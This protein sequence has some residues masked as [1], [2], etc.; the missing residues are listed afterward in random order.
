MLAKSSST[1]ADVRLLCTASETSFS[2]SE[3]HEAPVSPERGRL[4]PSLRS[5]RCLKTRDDVAIVVEDADNEDTVST[6]RDLRFV[7]PLASTDT[8]GL[9]TLDEKSPH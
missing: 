3:G 8:A 1:S 6:L 9:A 4:V 5:S 2:R 7:A